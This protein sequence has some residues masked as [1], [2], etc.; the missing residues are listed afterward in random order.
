MN[1]RQEQI[2]LTT[3]DRLLSLPIFDLDLL[4]SKI[5]NTI[6]E[7]IPATK[8]TTFLTYNKQPEQILYHSVG[9][10]TKYLKEEKELTKLIRHTIKL[11][12]DDSTSGR[13]V[14][15]SD[16]ILFVDNV[17]LEY[18]FKS[19]DLAKFLNLK[20]AV[21]LKL[22]HLDSADPFG[23]YIIYYDD[24]SPISS[25]DYKDFDLLI[26]TLE[27]VLSNSKRLKESRILQEVLSSAK[28]IK[29]DTK[30]FLQQVV[31]I[32]TDNL[33]A[34]ACSIFTVD[35][36]DKRIKLQATSGVAPGPKLQQKYRERKFTR[37][38]VFYEIGEGRTGKVVRDNKIKIDQKSDVSKTKWVDIGE[39]KTFAAVPI[40]KIDKAES[41]GVVRCATRPNKILD[42]GIKAFNHLDVE[43][44]KYVANL[45]SLFLE[46]SFYHD[47]QRQL[48]TKL[49]HEITSSLNN[50]LNELDI[51][52]LD[53]KMEAGYYTIVKT[54]KK[55]TKSIRDEVNLINL[56]VQSVTI[57]EQSVVDYSFEPTRLFTDIIEKISELLNKKA[58]V[59]RRIRISVIDEIGFPS[60][61]VDRLRM[62]M[63]FLNL[64]LNAIKY[65]TKL[66]RFDKSRNIVIN[67]GITD[68]RTQYIINVSNFGLRVPASAEN[69]IFMYGYRMP[70]A[71]EVDPTGKGIGLTL[72]KEI[73]D[74]HG[75]SIKL[76]NY[77]SPTTFSLFFPKVII[78]KTPNEFI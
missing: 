1:M 30:S 8:F 42:A 23:I 56:I 38:D 60:V 2:L 63:V 17:L 55:M 16:K 37:K 53:C 61:F 44:L 46:L 19:K 7:T 15:S 49:P 24:T 76:T 10:S 35:P 41:I 9:Y 4:C 18:D 25:F 62:K 68:D 51:L 28:K 54:I 3:I 58:F 43:Y 13:L 39:S 45:L 21:F 36:N 73:L 20:K 50:I 70:E 66:V 52:D 77:G 22:C 34:K 31:G 75:V 12:V 47:S 33:E 67:S 57:L 27:N 65:S 48:I 59:E 11:T 14:K 26:K 74:K 32:I 6:I 40:P 5:C 78:E 64:L 71:I 29:K 69:D 72:T